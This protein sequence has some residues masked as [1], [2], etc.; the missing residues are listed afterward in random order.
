MLCERFF[1][2]TPYNSTPQKLHSGHEYLSRGRDTFH[3]RTPK[4]H[5]SIKKV[6]PAGPRPP[7]HLPKIFGIGPRSPVIEPRTENPVPWH[8]IRDPRNVRPGQ[9]DFQG[10]GKMTSNDGPRD[11]VISRRDKA[12]GP[13]PPGNRGYRTGKSSDAAIRDQRRTARPGAPVP[14]HLFRKQLP[15]K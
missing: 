5:A 7:V 2:P 13:G 6:N 3:G 10:R 15:K 1:D 14:V 4:T 12:P 9:N 8:P 11:K